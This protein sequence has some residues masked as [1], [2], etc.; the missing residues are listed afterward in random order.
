MRPKLSWAREGRPAIQGRTRDVDS[1]PERFAERIGSS[2]GAG[3]KKLNSR[4]KAGGRGFSERGRV[5]FDWDR[6]RRAAV[7]NHK[8]ARG[9]AVVVAGIVAA[10]RL[11]YEYAHCWLCWVMRRLLC[12]FDSNSPLSSCGCGS[13][14]QPF[15]FGVMAIHGDRR[16]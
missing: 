7:Y 11:L 15:S 9:V 12:Q 4:A 3:T 8:C 13:F 14:L 1:S 16:R 5:R 2:W 6:Q 10:V